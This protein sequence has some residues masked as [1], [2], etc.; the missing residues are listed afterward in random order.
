MS[1]WLPLALDAGSV[2]PWPASAVVATLLGLALLLSALRLRRMQSL[3]RAGLLLVLQAGAALLLYL[4]L[5]PP[6]RA[7]A[8]PRLLTVLT[9]GWSQL[10]ATAPWPTADTVALADAEH[11]AGIARLPDLAALLRAQPQAV[12]RIVGH[13]LPAADREAARGRVQGFDAPP[14]PV[15]LV[16]LEAPRELTRGQRLRVHGRVQLPPAAG[17]AAHE[18][19]A[20][21]VVL[22]DPQQQDLDRATP[23]ADG[24]F[25]L[26]ALPRGS[27]PLSLQL[28]LLG[29]DGG[30]LDRLALPVAMVEPDRPRLLLL[31]GAPN[32]EWKYLRRWALDAGIELLGRV[33]LSPGI[34][35]ARG[36]AALDAALLQSLDAVLLDDRAWIALPAAQRELLLA[37]VRE[38][39][40]LLLR[41]TEDPDGAAHAALQPLGFE[42]R[43]AELARNVRLAAEHDPAG[44]APALARR[45]LAVSAPDA[46]PLLRAAAGQ[47]DAPQAPLALWRP[48]GDGRIALWWLSDSF[49]LPLAGHADLHATLWSDA[50]ATLARPRG[51]AT[52]TLLPPRSGVGERVVLCGRS[53]AGD[54]RLL[55]AE[56]VA[57]QQPIGERL[58]GCAALWPRAS[59][60]HRLERSEAPP[61]WL[62][63]FDGDD[64]P[65]LVVGERQRATRAL[66]ESAPLRSTDHQRP[67]P[68]TL[69]PGRDAPWPFLLGWLLLFGL[70][71]ALERRW[72]AAPDPPQPASTG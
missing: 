45:P 33:E 69:A 31:A 39:L 57:V 38:G 1:P 67:T 11:A 9:A 52:P 29:A 21:A 70:L 40:G 72:L 19:T 10:P 65:A 53:D 26:Q 18:A 30:E 15:G 42:L 27:G 2:L 3:R 44:A 24:R 32:P 48:H 7:P 64:S 23:D 59:G 8:A 14:L 36:E 16:E 71:A 68:A 4:T 41:L 55:D 58:S 20:P 17:G 56:G 50:L 49:R 25:L 22:R 60:W 13:G 37:A 28:V 34:A 43:T 35:Q 62:H 47:A 51:T 5:F 66:L 63:V 54:A 6:L 12:L 61:L 46:V